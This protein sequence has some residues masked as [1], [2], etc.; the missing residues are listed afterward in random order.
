MS[1][2]RS[3]LQR[4]S[5]LRAYAA[6][7]RAAPFSVAF[8]TCALKGSASDALAQLQVEKKAELDV[9][10][11]LAFSLFSGAYLG[12]GQHFVYNV[13][14]TRL[15]GSGTDWRTALRKVI[16]DSTVHVPCIY[17]PLYYPFETVVLGKGGIEDGLK[18]YAADAPAVLST[19]WCMWPG[20][21]ALSFSVIPQELRISFVACVSFFWL[22]YL[23]YASHKDD[24][25]HS[26]EA[27]QPQCK[28]P[29]AT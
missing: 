12:I 21:H 22:V 20:V 18:R 5:P 4:L 7:S 17:L 6:A 13:A 16:A 29:K 24:G 28:K 26:T 1:P 15:F 8:A 2:T 9:K 14:F 23:S 10:R 11:N 19:Y 3:L 27:E 25:S